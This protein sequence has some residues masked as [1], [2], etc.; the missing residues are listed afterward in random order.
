[1]H[2]MHY[3]ACIM[4]NTHLQITIRGIDPATKAALSQQAASEGL[5]LNRYAL[6]A[7]RRDAGT[8][9]PANRYRALQNFVSNHPV[10]G[11]DKKAF[12]AAVSWADTASLKKQREDE[13]SKKFGQ[14]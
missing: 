4:Q 2:K 7:L 10:N 14:S 12:D 13:A 8:D 6:R 11:R 9:G 5:S 1:M 3:N